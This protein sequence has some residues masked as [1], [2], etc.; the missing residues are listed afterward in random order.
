[1]VVAAG[2]VRI[3]PKKLRQVVGEKI[4]MATAEEVLEVTGYP[5]GGVCP[6]DLKTPV[7]ILLDISLGD[8]PVVYTAAGTANSALP[9]T[10]EQL[11]EITKGEVVS[12]VEEATRQA[13]G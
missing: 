10:L 8:Y 4:R 9:V 7:R 6:F 1:M 3:S 5:V 2:D 13:A 11:Q 12:V